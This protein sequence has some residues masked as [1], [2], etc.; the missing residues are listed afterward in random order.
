MKNC[1]HTLDGSQAGNEGGTAGR[2]GAGAVEA[3]SLVHG[4]WSLNRDLMLEVCRAKCADGLET[5]KTRFPG[6][7]FNKCITRTQK[8][9]IALR[10]YP[11]PE[12]RLMR[13]PSLS[14][15]RERLN[16]PFLFFTLGLSLLSW[17]MRMLSSRSSTSIS[18]SA[19]CCSRRFNSS[20]CDFCC[21]AARVSSSSLERSS[22]EK[23]VHRHNSTVFTNRGWLYNNASAENIDQ[24]PEPR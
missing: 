18:R 16:L 15:S 1:R 11:S 14:L 3:S 6:N 2:R 5:L 12:G 9:F 7:R 13:F 17:K 24:S 19:S 20:S 21:R 22:W 23:Q 4:R 8:L 10:C